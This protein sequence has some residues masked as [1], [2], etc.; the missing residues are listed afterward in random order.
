MIQE[1]GISE[2]RTKENKKKAK[3]RG[4]LIVEKGPIQVRKEEKESKE[5]RRAKL[6]MEHDL[7]HVRKQENKRKLES[8]KCKMKHD[9]TS[10]HNAEKKRKRLSR[11]VDSDKKRIKKFLKQTMFN[12]VFTCSCCQR[13]L[14]DCNVSIIDSKLI[15]DID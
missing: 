11:L 2:V 12:A 14:F 8:R 15:T 7:E 6:T 13:N 5:R 4:K 9:P 1:T 10:V 3:S